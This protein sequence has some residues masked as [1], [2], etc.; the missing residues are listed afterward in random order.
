[1][2]TFVTGCPH[3]KTQLKMPTAGVGAT[4]SYLAGV[5]NKAAKQYIKIRINVNHGGD[6]A[7]IQI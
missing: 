5:K 4:I 6:H 1:M 7:R 3:C 2:N